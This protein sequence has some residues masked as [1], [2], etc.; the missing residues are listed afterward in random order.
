[1][2]GPCVL[3]ATFEKSEIGEKR[4]RNFIA[5]LNYCAESLKEDR[6]VCTVFSSGEGITN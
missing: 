2:G 6:Y 1:M 5:F 3:G 4:V